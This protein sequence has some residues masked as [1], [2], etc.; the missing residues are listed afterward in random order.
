VF[1]RRRSRTGVPPELAAARAAFDE[2]AALVE[3][4]KRA[5]VAAVPRRRGAGAPLA[6]AVGGFEGGVREAEARMGA[7]SIASLREE[8]AACVAALEESSRRSERLRLELSPEGYE[9]LAPLLAELMEPLAAFEA[10]DTRF[11]EMGA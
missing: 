4:A 11:R 5:L 7:W 3:E 10:A 6:D 8:W 9:E 1:R 2:V